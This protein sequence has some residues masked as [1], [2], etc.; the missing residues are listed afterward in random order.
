MSAATETQGNVEKALR[1]EVE[2]LEKLVGSLTEQLGVKVAMEQKTT[3][4]L[5]LSH[6]KT[7]ELVHNY[8]SGEKS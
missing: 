8:C 7:F 1:R 6:G 3:L 2:R 5:K 4:S